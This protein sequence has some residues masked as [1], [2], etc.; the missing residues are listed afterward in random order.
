[1]DT[2]KGLIMAFDKDRF[3]ERAAIMEYD[4]G[5]TRFRAETEAATAQGVERWVAIGEVAGRIV[6]RTRNQRQAMAERSGQ[7]RMP[8]MQ[9]IAEEKT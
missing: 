7:D 1:M 2:G 6:E 9:R 4:G 5:L 3:E 8:T